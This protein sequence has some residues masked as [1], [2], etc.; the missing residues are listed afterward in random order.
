MLLSEFL[1]GKRNAHKKQGNPVVACNALYKTEK[2]VNCYITP[3]QAIA[4]A[5]NLL[6]KAQ[7]ILDE[8]LK[9]AV[10]H[11]W[12]Q[13]KE[14]ERLYCGLNHARKGPRKGTKIRV[15]NE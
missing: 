3:S 10:V 1:A 14:N 8:N 7:L 15:G 6:Q 5:R 13:G 12:N 2:N 9:D 11:L 4:L